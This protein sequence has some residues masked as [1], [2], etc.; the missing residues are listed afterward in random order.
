MDKVQSRIYSEVIF[1]S[2]SSIYVEI[3]NE[4]YIIYLILNQPFIRQWQIYECISV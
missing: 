2:I 1:I 4:R 3:Y